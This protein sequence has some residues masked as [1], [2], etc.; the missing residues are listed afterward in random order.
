MSNKLNPK[1]APGQPMIY[2]ITIEGHL[3]QKWTDWFDGLVITLEDDGNTH[4]TG[5]VVDQAA[6]HGLLKKVRDLGMSL[7]SVC[8]VSQ[9][10]DEAPDLTQ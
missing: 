5:P 9:N 2:Q 10:Q 7:I 4:L 1:N 6:L 3:G 8:P